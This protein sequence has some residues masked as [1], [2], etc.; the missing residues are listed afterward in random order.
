MKHPDRIPHVHV[1]YNTAPVTIGW[2]RITPSG[3]PTMDWHIITIRRYNKG[4]LVHAH[5]GTLS[6][7]S[8]QYHA[9]KDY[10]IRTLADVPPELLHPPKLRKGRGT[11]SKP[12]FR[13][14]TPPEVAEGNWPASWLAT[15]SGA[16]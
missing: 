10:G 8:R 14:F 2:Y 13:E 11:W 15:N 4:E 12:L 7:Y 5:P 1:D 16:L 3:R 9:M 6:P